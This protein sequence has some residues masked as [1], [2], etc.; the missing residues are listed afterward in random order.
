M[1]ENQV[2]PEI[3][4]HTKTKAENDIINGARSILLAIQNDSSLKKQFTTSLN[5]KSTDIYEKVIKMGYPKPS[6]G[7][8]T[9]RPAAA[10]FLTMIEEFQHYAVYNIKIPFKVK[11]IF[12]TFRKLNQ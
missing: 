12:K 5:E 7:A 3:T 1:D 11:Q 9:A 8:I 2:K 10:I 4:D 6:I